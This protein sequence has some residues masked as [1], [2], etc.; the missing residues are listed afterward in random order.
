M[1]LTN[2]IFT[3]IDS[4]FVLKCRMLSFTLGA[5][6]LRPLCAMLGW[7]TYVT[8]WLPFHRGAPEEFRACSL[9][10]VG[11]LGPIEPHTVCLVHKDSIYHCKPEHSVL[12]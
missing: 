3:Q 11:V 6:C 1:T 7:P 12:L 2:I 10:G 5:Q 9:L 8:Q 4:L